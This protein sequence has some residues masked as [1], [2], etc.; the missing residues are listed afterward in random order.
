MNPEEKR[1][2]RRELIFALAFFLGA[3]PL[4]MGLLYLISL[5]VKGGAQ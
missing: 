5:F 4:V 3:W 2:D 1:A